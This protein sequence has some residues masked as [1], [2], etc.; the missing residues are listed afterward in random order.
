[1]ASPASGRTKALFDHASRYLVAG[2]S[3]SARLNAATGRPLYLTHGDGPRIDDVD[4]REFLDYNLSHGATFR[5]HNHPAIKEAIERALGMG[6][7]CAYETEYHAQA[8]QLIAETVP[9][10][11]RVRFA[12]L[13]SEATLGAIRLA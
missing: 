2:V 10:A 12:Y 4:G 6:V 3:G 7:I 9:A 8:A 13:G 1:M 11:D 5:G